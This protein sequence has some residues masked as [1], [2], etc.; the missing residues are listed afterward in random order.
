MV[1]NIDYRALT[2]STRTTVPV[3]EISNKGLKYATF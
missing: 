1:E 3:V 2:S